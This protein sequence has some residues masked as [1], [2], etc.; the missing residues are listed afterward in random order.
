MTALG[1]RPR[2]AQAPPAGDVLDTLEP[3]LLTVAQ[4]AAVLGRT[5]KQTRALLETGRL[6]GFKPGGRHGSRWAVYRWAVEGLAAGEQGIVPG[7]LAG[8]FRRFARLQAELTALA[9]EIEEDL[10]AAS[11]CREPGR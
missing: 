11:L 1:E 4:A 6:A 7:V 10:Q 8:K 3:A 2:P 5:E 9:L